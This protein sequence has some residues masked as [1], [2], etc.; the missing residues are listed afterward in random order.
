VLQEIFNVPVA[1]PK[2]MQFVLRRIFRNELLKNYERNESNP[3]RKSC[4]RAFQAG[5][6]ALPES[7]QLWNCEPE[8]TLF[9]ELLI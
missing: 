7:P 6:N 1:N 9:Y 8:T 5:D 3:V 2:I 4:Y